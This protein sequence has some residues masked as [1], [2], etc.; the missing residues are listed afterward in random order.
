MR[1]PCLMSRLAFIQAPKTLGKCASFSPPIRI[2]HNFTA[3]RRGG[4]APLVAFVDRVSPFSP[5]F[6]PAVAWKRE[7][8]SFIC[9]SQRKK[10]KLNGSDNVQTFLAAAAQHSHGQ[11]T[12]RAHPTRPLLARHTHLPLPA[13]LSPTARLSVGGSRPGRPS[14]RP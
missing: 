10:S 4:A 6:A 8:C 14:M 3:R 9:S 12:P 2:I 5:M 7:G 11:R 13:G 1:Y